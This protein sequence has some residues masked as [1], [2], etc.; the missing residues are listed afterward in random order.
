MSNDNMSCPCCGKQLQEATAATLR[1]HFRSSVTCV[2]AVLPAVERAAFIKKYSIAPCACDTL[3]KITKQGKADGRHLSACAAQNGGERILRRW[4]DEE[5]HQHIG[6]ARVRQFEVA[7]DGALTGAY[8][9]VAV[10]AEEPARSPQ[11]PRCRSSTTP[12]RKTAEIAREG[13]ETAESESESDDDFLESAEQQRVSANTRSRARAQNKRTTAIIASIHSFSIT[14]SRIH[15]H[16]LTNADLAPNAVLPLPA[17]LTTAAHDDYAAIGT[18]ASRPLHSNAVTH[19]ESLTRAPDVAHRE[20]QR[21]ERVGQ[22]RPGGE[23][24]RG[25]RQAPAL[26]LP[27]VLPVRLANPGAQPRMERVQLPRKA[28]AVKAGEVQRV[29]RKRWGH[30]TGA[31]CCPIP[32]GR[33]ARAAG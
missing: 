9:D 33:E 19:K 4:K 29:G 18:A 6:G 23:P 2:F 31:E 13:R 11:A 32:D 17:D 3:V 8:F 14:L 25:E 22:Q 30:G 21:G 5:G 24:Q 1:L 15:D 10:D 20:R 28:L 12:T 26:H 7:Q 27:Q 16:M